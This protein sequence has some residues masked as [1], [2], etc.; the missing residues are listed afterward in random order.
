M[1]ITLFEKDMDNKEK[2]T[3]SDRIRRDSIKAEIM[4]LES[5]F[6]NNLESGAVC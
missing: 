4:K 3:V 5:D 1:K 2:V 6:L